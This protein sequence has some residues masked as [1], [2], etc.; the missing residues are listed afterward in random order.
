M[1][2]VSELMRGIGAAARAAAAELA[3]APP[4]AKRAALLA[5]AEA[6]AAGVPEILAA[7]AKDMAFGADKGL[8]AAMLDRLK[9]DEGR[10]A[11]IHRD[12]MVV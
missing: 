2:D 7:N 11:L 1:E 9:L 5:A 8:S 6:V 12:D 10:A 4:E 3:F